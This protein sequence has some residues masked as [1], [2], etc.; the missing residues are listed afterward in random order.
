MRPC[1]LTMSAF[2]PYAGVTVL[3]LERLGSRGLY[4]IAGDTG[5]GKTTIFDAVT[6]A[7]YGAASGENREPDM[8]RSLYA[9]P[10]TPTYVE[11]EFLC[12]GK[13]YRVRR[14][15]EYLRPKGRGEGMTKQRAEAELYYPDGRPPVTKVKEVTRAVEELLGLDKRQFTQVAMIAQGDFLK[16]LL[17]KTE[18]RSRIFREIFHTRLYQVLQE[19]LKDE[20]SKLRAEYEEAGRSFRQYAGGIRCGAESL[21][22]KALEAQREKGEWIPAAELLEV[23]SRILEEDGEQDSIAARR[24]GEQERQLE[25]INQKLGRAEAA[26]KA[27]ERLAQEE[28]ALNEW[29]PRYAEALEQWEAEQKKQ[30]QRDA[31]ALQIQ[32][33]TQRLGEYDEVEALRRKQREQNRRGA[34]IAGEL[35][36]LE[37]EI[38]EIGQKMA[39]KKELL[40]EWEDLETDRQE[41]L[42]QRQD[43]THEKQQLE[44]LNKL[45]ESCLAMERELETVRRQYLKQAD[46]TET[47]RRAY[48][49][50]ER[51]FL[52]EQAG[53]LATTLKAGERCPVCGSLDHPQPAKMPEE[54]PTR[55]ELKKAKERLAADEER[56]AELSRQAGERNGTYGAL[57]AQF[58]EQ[59]EGMPQTGDSARPEEA[60]DAE[61]AEGLPGGEDSAGKPNGEVDDARLGEILEAC[62][63]KNK[64]ALTETE[65]RLRFLT[66]QIAQ[67][68][69]T[70]KELPKLEKEQRTRQEKQE[71]LRREQAALQAQ[72]GLLDEQI[73]KGAA[74]LEYESR[75]IAEEKIQQMAAAK[76]AMEQNLK[77]I[78]A[79]YEAGKKAVERG[80]ASVKVLKEQLAGEPEEDTDALSAR[81]AELQESRAR[82]NAAHTEISARIAANRQARTELERQQAQIGEL[83]QRWAWVRALSNTANGNLPGKD[84]IMLETYIQ[85]ACFD[86]TLMRANIRLMT[87]TGGQYELARRVEAANQRSQSGLE[88]DVI[89]HYNGSRRSVQT[90]SGGEAFKASLSLALGLSDE[91]QASAGGIQLDTMFVDEGFGSLDEESL[92]QALRALDDLSEGNRLVGIISHVAELKERIDRQ[93]VV[94]KDRQGGSRAKIIGGML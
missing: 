44:N 90:L 85:M 5:A 7:L 26:R 45:R 66:Q 79:T 43:L 12:R 53:V 82:L 57:R 56:T 29:E 28:A 65:K 41:L 3:E 31:L 36:R 17:A 33:A 93:I 55:E 25:E 76:K 54:A 71:E 74:A 34:K 77:E 52:D 16:L 94:T 32:T 73:R 46:K 35:E 78:Q 42:R 6:Y 1:K 10:Q 91:I 24:L 38:G 4:L 18:D 87:M 84:K 59:M 9:D 19:R 21:Y 62:T 47:S 70:E 27:Q 60:A 64:E 22:R 39:E 40:A 15:P 68:Q 92:N 30:P 13:R 81:R 83:E 2:G 75:K 8:L 48:E 37:K 23:L 14:C 58:R 88:L 69:E 67:K 89:D 51:A 50:K 80:R 72:A 49:K 86:R 61:K 20:S 11:M 63:E